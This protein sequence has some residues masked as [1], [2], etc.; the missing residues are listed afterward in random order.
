MSKVDKNNY[1]CRGVNSAK[2]IGCKGKG[3]KIYRN[4]WLVKAQS[5]VSGV[6]QLGS[7]TL[8]N[9]YV[10]KKIRFKIEVMK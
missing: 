5:E 4:W 6:V 10:G 3:E 9:Q 7:I 2:K 8:P 1:V